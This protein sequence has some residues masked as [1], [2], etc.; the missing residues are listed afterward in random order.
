MSDDRKHRSSKPTPADLAA[1]GRLRAAWGNRP[2]GLT[3]EKMGAVLGASQSAVSHYLSGRNAL[4][5]RVLMLFAKAL[6]I[7]PL[8][9]R[10]DLPEQALA[11]SVRSRVT[12]PDET[13]AHTHTTGTETLAA[14]A[15]MLTETPEELRPAVGKLLESL[16]MTPDND[17]VKE[18]LAA[19]LKSG[20][21]P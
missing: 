4:N 7:D 9:I 21:D 18:S 17:K 3:Q 20:E 13:P 12:A 10:D 8:T 14:L 1:A 11:P 6:D 2:K 15:K 16:A 5:Y 19:V